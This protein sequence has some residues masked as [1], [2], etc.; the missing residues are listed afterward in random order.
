M[1]SGAD[2]GNNTLN[3]VKSSKERNICFFN[4]DLVERDLQRF[5]RRPREFYLHGC[6]LVLDNM[7]GINFRPFIKEWAEWDVSPQT[8]A[9]WIQVTSLSSSSVEQ[10]TLQAGPWGGIE[11]LW[12]LEPRLPVPRVSLPEHYGLGISSCLP[13]LKVPSR[14]RQTH[15][16][17]DLIFYA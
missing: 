4:S 16:H 9:L 13:A 17:S 10:R 3:L 11:S 2:T 15:R 7:Q 5:R 8:G 12:A 1:S 6:N 14:H